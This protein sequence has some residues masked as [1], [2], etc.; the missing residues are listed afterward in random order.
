MVTE[1]AL[2]IRLGTQ[3]GIVR[4][5]DVASSRL[6][7]AARALRGKSVEEALRLV[8]LVFAVCGTAHRVALARALDASDP[9]AALEAARGAMCLAEAIG[10]HV[11]QTALAWRRAAGAPVE[12]DAARAA[13]AHAAALADA[14]EGSPR[15]DLRAARAEADDLA[16]LVARFATED[17]P[18][19]REIVRA[20]RAT[21]GAAS[22]RAGAPFD[23]ATV[24]RAL[25]NEPAFAE[26]PTLAGA[27]FD[28]STFAV[29]LDDAE[30]AAA[31]I[32]ERVGLLGRLIARRTQ[33]RRDL[34]ALYAALSTLEALD[35]P[36]PASRRTDGTGVGWAMTARGPLVYWVETERGVVH[37]VRLV[38]P[39]DWTFH[40]DG[41]LRDA[42][43]G[44]AASPTLVRDAG[45]LVL[46]LDPCV[47]WSIEVGNA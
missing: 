9:D 47:P 3:E 28:A 39:T 23:P 40:P 24:G 20:D 46:A 13:R 22:L 32:G 29:R 34:T 1:G 25:A 4:R 38:A 37:D 36:A 12:A 44:Q 33:M 2:T 43:V 16:V 6:V 14:L 35:E 21:F 7:Q 11:M 27:P 45:W 30:L 31:P 19:A 18:L 41:P 10:S 15:R 8:P 5:V 17:A 26:R 42:L